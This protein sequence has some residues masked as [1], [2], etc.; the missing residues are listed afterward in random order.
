MNDEF[1][2]NLLVFF[3]EDFIG[4]GKTLAIGE[5]FAIVHDGGGKAGKAGDFAQ[6]LRDVARAE[7]DGARRACLGAGRCEFIGLDR[8]T[9]GLGALL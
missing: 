2:E 6:A 1:G 7:N 9:L 8:T 3:G 4:F 5:G